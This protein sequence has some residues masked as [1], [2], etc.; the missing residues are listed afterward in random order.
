MWQAGGVWRVWRALPTCHTADGMLCSLGSCPEQLPGTGTSEVV[1]E[2]QAGPPA[3]VSRGSTDLQ[4]PSRGAAGRVCLLPQ[5]GCS[6]QSHVRPARWVS[7]VRR[8]VCHWSGP[9]PACLALVCMVR[10]G[11][12]L[13]VAPGGWSSDCVCGCARASQLRWPRGHRGGTW[14]LYLGRNRSRGIADP[15]LQ[16]S[17][18]GSVRGL[19]GE[20]RE[21]SSLGFYMSGAKQGLA[22]N[23]GG[24]SGVCVRTLA[25]VGTP[26]PFW[27]SEKV[28]ELHPPS[29][30]GSRVAC[31]L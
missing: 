14:G 19:G 21:G 18:L 20:G 5:P 2:H 3:L 4:Q 24:N 27:E 31:S 12:C 9:G 26:G 13:C 17:H 1:D 7:L 10:G 28:P 8:H 25:G 15:S 22:Q 11:L 23:P 16:P 30:P 6:G 29:P